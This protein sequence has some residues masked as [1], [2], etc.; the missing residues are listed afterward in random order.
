MVP[1]HRHSTKK[2][3]ES[4]KGKDEESE[5]RTEEELERNTENTMLP[6]VQ[7]PLSSIIKVG[8]VV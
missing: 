3:K 7:K 2:L 5:R 8:M 4:N 1:C 6:N